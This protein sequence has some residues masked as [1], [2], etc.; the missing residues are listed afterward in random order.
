MGNQMAI[1]TPTDQVDALLGEISA[2]HGLET[3]FA[4]P[5][6]ATAEAAPAHAAPV[7]ED[8]LNSRLAALRGA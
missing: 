6:A 5:S 4:L 2:E 8:D 3:Q 7:K 1:S